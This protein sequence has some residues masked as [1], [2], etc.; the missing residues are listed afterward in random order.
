[1]ATAPEV[2]VFEVGPDLHKGEPELHLRLVSERVTAEELIRARVAR[3]VERYNA[4]ESA[5]FV[6]FERNAVEGRLN[7]SRGRVDVEVQMRHAVRAFSKNRYLLFV[8]DRQVEGLD[9]VLVLKP[10]SEVLFVRLVPL[11]G[12]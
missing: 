9:E 1:M 7:A 5:T 3:E 6:D 4:E 12:G 8:D 11:V 10:Q 2:Q